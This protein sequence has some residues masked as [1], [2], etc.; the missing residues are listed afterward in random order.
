MG[1]VKH[2]KKQRVQWGDKTILLPSKV[3]E[4]VFKKLI[5][6]FCVKKESD[7]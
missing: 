3:S 1:S 2:S 7:K 5:Q 4:H 6:P